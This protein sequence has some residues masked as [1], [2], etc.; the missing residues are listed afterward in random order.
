MLKKC[1]EQDEEY[2]GKMEF[3]VSCPDNLKF[4]KDMI[5]TYSNEVID[6]EEYCIYSESAYGKCCPVQ[7]EFGSLLCLYLFY[8][9]D[10]ADQE[11]R[12][13][14]NKVMGLMKSALSRVK[15][16]DSL[17][18]EYGKWLKIIPLEEKD[19][20][21]GRNYRIAPNR[22][23]IQKEVD[24]CGLFAVL[25]N[26]EMSAEE[27]LSIIR[28][29]DKSEKAFNRLKNRRDHGENGMPQAGNV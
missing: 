28:K 9:P 21:T 16:S 14:H 15:Y 12:S 4:V 18:R 17:E 23:N 3:A 7:E 8:D 10:R 1:E 2:H 29:R 6:N 22:E 5:N 26:A 24:K 25:S 11:K 19:P 27:M 13:I 20:T